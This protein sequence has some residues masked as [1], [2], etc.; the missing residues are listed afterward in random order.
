MIPKHSRVL[1]GFSAQARPNTCVFQGAGCRA[2]AG[3]ERVLASVKACFVCGL[4]PLKT[5]AGS[6]SYDTS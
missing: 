6:I 5:E 3:V 4:R 1:E 2:G